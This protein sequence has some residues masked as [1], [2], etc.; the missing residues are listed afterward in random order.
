M[1]C[2]NCGTKN[3]DDALFCENCGE[4]LEEQE[5][6]VIQNIPTIYYDQVSVK[7]PFSK[8]LIIITLELFS[9]ILLIYGIVTFGKNFFSAGQEAEGYF[10][11][12]ANGD[13]KKAYKKLDLMES[14]FITVEQFQRANA[15]HSLGIVGNYQLQKNNMDS[16]IK[17]KNPLS[18]EVTIQ[19]QAEG[20][21][22]EYY[23]TLN[24]QPGKRYYLFDDWK[25][26]ASSQICK[27]YMVYVPKGAKVILDEI[28]LS[29]KYLVDSNH[30]AKEFLDDYGQSL[31]NSAFD[32]YQ[33]PEI[34]Y[35]VHNI[36]VSMEDMEDV[37]QKVQIT[38]TDKE[39]QLNT[40]RMKQEVVEKLIQVAGKNM[41]TIYHAAI[42]SQD[43]RDITSIFTSD[44]GLLPDIEEC[45]QELMSDLQENSSKPYSIQF[46]SISGRALPAYGSSVH[47]SFAYDLAYTYEDWWS[48]DMQK[49]VYSGNEELTF[50][51]VK[52]N[53]RWVQSSLGCKSLYY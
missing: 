32:V 6:Q 38:E 40:M 35:G 24:R 37:V 50:E 30:F 13:F 11:C 23:V 8:L 43:F 4:K 46:H 12:M 2:Q 15:G 51:F 10:V 25:V 16:M 53:G 26:D 34:F 5:L 45:Y 14:E 7:K 9:I 44:K 48:G 27:E 1:Y 18:E 19:Y 21:S 41:G 28:P 39:Y 52:E 47:I 3:A 22:L 17:Q 49:N 20:S 31:P 29:E 33:I 36:T 42:C